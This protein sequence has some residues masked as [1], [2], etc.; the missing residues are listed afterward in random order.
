MKTAP[1]QDHM[2]CLIGDQPPRVWSLLITVFGELAQDE[3]ARLS[4]SLLRHI[5]ERIGIKPE[6]MRVALHRLRKDGWIASQ[7]TGRTSAYFLTPWGRRQSAQASPLIYASG[8]LAKRAWLVLSDPGQA[9]PADGVTGTW[10]SSN[11]RVTS[12]PGTPPDT[13]VTPLPPDIPLPGWMTSRLCDSATIRLSQEFAEALDTLER[14]L[15][16]APELGV[17]D[18]AVLRVLL[19]HGWRRIVL[20]A[21]RLPDHLFPDDWRGPVCRQR[22]FGLLT[23][24]PKQDLETLTTAIATDARA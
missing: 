13:F 14:R 11:L 15:T 10:L 3:G 7:R 8:P 6:A 20:K 16:G 24:Y 4:G 19:V 21:P 5:S 12:D 2:M 9:Q 23:R 1:S 22:V 18:I 17:L